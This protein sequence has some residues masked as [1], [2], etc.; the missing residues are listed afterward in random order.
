MQFAVIL[1]RVLKAV[2][3]AG[4]AAFV[5]GVLLTMT[6]IGLR[7]VSTLT[8]KGAVDLMQL[9]VLTG[10]ML[11]I[12]HAFLSDQH[13]AIDLF[14]ERMPQP[15]QLVL[16]IFAAF[17]ATAFLSAVLYFSFW[18]AMSEAGDRSQ[19]IEIPMI[20]YW[21]PFLVG[22]GLSVLANIALAVQL[23]CRGLPPKE[24]V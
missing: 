9:C 10:A 2:S 17:L 11:A 15:V 24:T 4:T 12:P 14:A 6:D 5:L 1:D 19:T 20:W 3:L 22:I 16:R 8:V 13:V 23:V 7:S 18:Q 21:T